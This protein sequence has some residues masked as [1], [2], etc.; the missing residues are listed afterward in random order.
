MHVVS[1]SSLPSA[2]GTR[3]CF[4]FD[5]SSDDVDGDGDAVE[6]KVG[7]DGDDA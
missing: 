4:L 5:I 1:I 6:E 2:I 7:E 3:T